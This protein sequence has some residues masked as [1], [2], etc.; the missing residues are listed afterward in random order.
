MKKINTRFVLL[1]AGTAVILGAGT[2]AAHY[3]QTARIGQALLGQA[4]RAEKDNRPDLAVKYLGRYLEFQP[5]DNEQRARLGKLLASDRLASTHRAREKALF[6][7]EQVL[8]REPARHE[9]RPIVIRLAIELKQLEVAK[10]HL[11]I[12]RKALP[13]DSQV[14]F[15]T[16]Q[17][18]EAKKQPAEAEQ[19]YGKAIRLS[20]QHVE[21]YLRQAD[22]VQQRLRKG[23]AAARMR[24]VEEIYDALV[25]NNPK[26]VPAYLARYR[27]RQKA[28]V[29]EAVQDLDKAMELAPD[30]ADVLLAAADFAEQAKQFD[31]AR[32]QLERGLKLHPGDVRMYEAI[33]WLEIQA[34]QR[35]KGL[36]YVR[37][38]LA[39]AKGD[40]RKELLW[41][42]AN[43]LLDGNDITEAETT[44][45]QMKQMAINPAAINYL[46]ARVLIC[47]G[48]W[49]EAAR[50]LERTRPLLETSPAVTRQLDLF[51]GQCYEQLHEPDQQLKAYT[52][53]LD[54]EPECVAARLGAA[55]AQGALGRTGDAL[56]Q[57]KQ[58]AGL[59]GAPPGARF[60]LARLLILHNLQTGEKDWQKAEKALRDAEQ[61]QPDALEVVLLRVELLAAQNQL[62]AAVDLLTEMRQR[63]PKKVEFRT[64]LA[65]LLLRRDEADKARALLDEAEQQLG[66]SLA[67]RLARA[68][69]LAT[70]P[71][72]EAAPQLE[73]LAAGLDRFEPEERSRLLGGLAE[74]WM[75]LGDAGQ[76]ERIWLALAREPQH[77]NDLNL[78]LLLFDLALRNNDDGGMKRLQDDIHRVEGT[79]GPLTRYAEAVRIIWRH[80]QGQKADLDDARAHL[81]YVASQRPAWSAV[82]LAKGEI[83]MIKGNDEQAIAD[84]RRAIE[85]GERGPR[86]IR[87]LVELLYARQRY[88]EAD[89]EIRRLQKQT[90]IAADMHRLAADLSLRNQDAARAVELANAAVSANSKD[91]RDHL[92]LGQVL[93]AGGKQPDKAEQ[94]LRRAVE[95]AP[96]APEA[97][98]ALVRFLVWS[99]Q[100]QAAEKALAEAA[101]KLSADKLHLAVGQC[102]EALGNLEKARLSY[103]AALETRPLTPAV[104]RGVAAF[105]LRTGKPRDAEPLLRQ[106]LDDKAKLSESEARWARHNLALVLAIAG[107]YAQFRQALTMVD[108]TVDPS[109]KIVETAN[110]EKRPEELRA[111]AHVLAQQPQRP[112]RKKAI[113]LLEEMSRGQWLT[114]DDQFLLARLYNAENNWP[115]ARGLLRDLVTLQ[116]RNPLY[117]MAYGEGLA[118]YKELAEAEAVIAKLDQLESANK[119]EPGTYATVQLRAL[120]LEGRGEGDKAIEL[121]RK[122]VAR[123]GAPADEFLL[124]VRYLEKQK[125]I[126]EALDVCEKALTKCPPEQVTAAAVVLVRTANAPPAPCD[127]VEGWLKAALAKDER[128]VILRLHLA[129]LL[130][131]RG[132]YQDVIAQYAIILQNDPRNVAAL[133]NQAWFMAQA[134]DKTGEALP[135]INRAIDLMG[136]RADLLDTRAVVQL[137][138]GRAD[139]AVADLERVTAE[140]PSAVRWFRLACAYK[141]AHRPDGATR[142][143]RQARDMGLQLSQLHPLERQAWGELY[144]ELRK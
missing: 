7:L 64:M 133:N 2:A 123:S 55:A 73:K 144:E 110:A 14:A 41:S 69:Y 80:R 29:L 130:E 58:L 79:Q 74:V 93:A 19:W 57:Y 118:V 92:W 32:T 10:E 46:L 24:P 85:L 49:A 12:L 98:V 22:L 106:M 83:E 126:D 81:D 72:E 63:E 65:A 40:T 5:D 103:R 143:F 18:Y 84:L 140:A 13:E 89:Q 36:D 59:P 125:R 114:P 16:A 91:F 82:L 102:Q 62:D 137:K 99:E 77:A 138:L 42:F 8:V 135:L 52:R 142:A 76:A 1:L 66:D 38:A 11:E 112:N 120:V 48:Q 71:R 70:R 44:I 129:D 61:A 86:V 108:L 60:E 87:K 34:G 96:A 9:L 31:K 6:V 35:P 97:H 23:K 95:L 54:Y 67:L 50:V 17:W 109:G 53:V 139:L 134:G 43:L 3:F 33:A 111:R 141:L 124:L 132:R 136:P 107:D 20:P 119:V 15:Q 131:A 121:I 88:A 127:R 122:Y 27:Y 47:K 21:S 39:G 51:L 68:R 30:D 104:L 100:R 28:G 45:V 90:L 128:S 101:D 116:N 94:E 78:R 25:A 56:A 37:Q 26:S 115:K 113:S 117:L 4:D 105:Y 75:R